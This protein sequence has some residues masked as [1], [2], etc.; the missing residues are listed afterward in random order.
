MW[1]S[2]CILI[3]WVW[4]ISCMYSWAHLDNHHV[5][6]GMI[7]FVIKTIK[8]SLYKLV[9][10]ATLILTWWLSSLMAKILPIT[11]HWLVEV[12]HIRGLEIITPSHSLHLTVN[13][14]TNIEVEQ[15]DYLPSWTSLQK[16]TFRVYFKRSITEEVQL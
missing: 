11:D 1:Y 16:T 4:E 2:T 15:V 5:P 14:Q 3:Q 12:Y 7:V 8:S 9:V 10:L 13:S 6:L